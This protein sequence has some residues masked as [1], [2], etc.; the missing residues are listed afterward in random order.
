MRISMKKVALGVCSAVM[1]SPVMMNGAAQAETRSYDVEAFTAVKAAT[2][3]NVDI[4]VGP[5]QSISADGP[6]GEMDRLQIISKSGRLVV[7]RKSKKRWGWNWGDD[8]NFNVTITMPELNSIDVS[9]GASVDAEGVNS[10]R[11]ILDASSGADIDVGGTCGIVSADAS[12]GADINA[13]DLVCR[14][15][16]ADV[17]SGASIDVHATER[18]DGDASS[19]GGISVHGKPT[20]V[21]SSESS[22]GG[23]RV[24]G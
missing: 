14:E 7:K 6:D 24:R 19:G 13:R 12:S 2:G 22:G 9:S 17:S 15:A 21:N 11:V 5:A 3:V 10:E 20:Q 18:F 8:S 4:K 1:L 23:I 16:S